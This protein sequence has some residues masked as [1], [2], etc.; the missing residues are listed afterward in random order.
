MRFIY[1]LVPLLLGLALLPNSA[2]A[3][4][5]WSDNSFSFLYGADYKQV[6]AG[7]SSTARVMTF[8]HASGHNWGKLF[9]FVDR[10]QE[11]D[12]DYR[13]T[14]GELSP[15]IYLKQFENGWVKSINAAFMYE[16]GSS[17]TRPTMGTFS[18]DNYLA[19]ISL[20]LNIPGMDFFDAG[21]YH[22]WDNNTFGRSEDEQLTLAG[23]WHY[24]NFI[25]DG[26][27]DFTPSKGSK[28]KE[29]E[30][31]FTP[32]ITYDVAPALGIKGKLKLGVEYSYWKNKFGSADKTT[33]NN[34]S[35]LVKW[36]L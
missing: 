8:E 23:A 24:G 1:K 12:G 7:R 31:N 30:L 6:P 5:Y 16:F 26:F 3:E 2:T 20:S 36:H 35:L 34:V 27:L 18:Q 11:V 17:T 13:E 29:T 14:Y 33:Q 25:V 4:Q 32:Q 22:A 9:M 21:I 28:H 15:T 10:I 19:G